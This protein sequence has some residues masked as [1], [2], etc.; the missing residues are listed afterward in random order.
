MI[1]KQYIDLMEKV[2]CA[3]SNDQI[4]LYIENVIKNGL[5]EHGFPRVTS[6]LGILI[7]HGKKTE[8]TSKFLKMMELCCDEIPIARDKNGLNVGNDFS[9]KEIVFC[10]LEIEKS[11]V[12]DKETTDRWREKLSRIVPDKTYS[13]ISPFP[14]VRMGNWAAFAAASEQVRK[15]AG[16]GCENA[17]IENQISSQLFSFDLNG[18]YRD[19]PDESIVYDIVTRLQL[20]VALYFGYSGKNREELEEFILKSADITLKMQSVSGEIPFGGRS[21]QFLHNEAFFAAICEF[22]ASVFREKG[23]LKKA[24]KFKKGAQRAIDSII[25]WLN[26]EPIYHIKNYYDTSSKFGCEEYAYFDKYMVT[27]GSWL[28]LAYIFSDENT[29]STLDV[30]EDE[31]YIC[32]ASQY[33]N[34]LFCRF[35]EY[36]VEIDTKANLH[37]DSNGVGRIHKNDTP[38]AICISVPFT[39][40][41]M[42]C[43][44][45]KNP[46]NYSITGIVKNK[47]GLVFGFDEGVI[48]NI[49]EKRLDAESAFIRIECKNKDKHLFYMSCII[50]DD[51]VEII[52]EGENEVG[53]TFPVFAFDG[54]E[55]TDIIFDEKRVEVNYKNSICVFESKDLIEDMDMILANRNG[56]YKAFAVYG[57]GKVSL[58]I[59]MK[60]DYNSLC[61]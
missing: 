40:T 8:L 23:D 45:I 27:T 5:C 59:S 26:N 51:G 30:S 47:D 19:F 56:H 49:I 53:L 21:N 38:S 42:Y 54:K 14:P 57:N 35:N 12:F 16:I 9:V 1:K 18:M 2:F 33:F 58:K 31:N 50:S 52:V 15:Y 20:A 60:R 44:D 25:P 29:N 48:H 61:N 7:A 10:L 24:D 55:E 43:T 17:F 13:S 46:T 41:P 34:K 11:K 32:E 6:N 3:Y 39:A 28:F 36:F 22:Y 4:D 37:Y